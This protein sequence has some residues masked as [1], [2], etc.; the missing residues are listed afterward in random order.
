MIA[1]RL[2]SSRR[3]G[4]GSAKSVGG[5]DFL[6]DIFLNVGLGEL[7][8]RGNPIENRMLDRRQLPR[9]GHGQELLNFSLLC[10]LGAIRMP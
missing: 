10:R 5:V 3:E 7:H 6:D 1:K 2:L 8:D 4:H 9:Q